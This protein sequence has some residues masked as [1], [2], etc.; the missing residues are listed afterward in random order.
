MRRS[1][2]FVSRSASQAT[3]QG[4]RACSAAAAHAK[5]VVLRQRAREPGRPPA[6]CQDTGPRAF[7]RCL[8]G[9]AL[10]PRRMLERFVSER[11][12]WEVWRRP[13][14]WVHDSARVLRPLIRSPHQGGWS[15][16]CSGPHEAKRALRQ[17]AR[18]SGADPGWFTHRLGFRATL[19]HNQSLQP[20][21]GSS[22][23][24]S[25]AAAE[26]HRYASTN[27]AWSHL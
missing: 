17:P 6:Q 14:L 9:L 12:G 15:M 23:R 26:L 3:I 2:R 11:A 22:L 16:E 27:M 8:M 5:S 24:S 21:S 1:G 13:C 10:A 25:P 20:T 19:S 7:F 18:E 4:G